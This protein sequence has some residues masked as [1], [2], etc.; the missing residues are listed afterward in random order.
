VRALS[1]E[2]ARSMSRSLRRRLALMKVEVN[3]QTWR[4]LEMMRSIPP[5]V[6][7]STNLRV[8]MQCRPRKERHSDRERRCAN[9]RAALSRR[10]S[11][12]YRYRLPPAR[13][14]PEWPRYQGAFGEAKTL[15]GVTLET[16]TLPGGRWGTNKLTEF[17]VTSQHEGTFERY[18]SSMA[19]APVVGSLAGN[20]LKRFRLEVRDS[21]PIRSKKIRTRASSR[22]FTIRTATK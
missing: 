14:H 18:M 11:A 5:P 9:H 12:L 22:T 21:Y 4:V 8:D 10:Q 7:Y 19:A 1:M 3:N 17:G 13:T 20:V 2:R 15:G 6:A 16:M